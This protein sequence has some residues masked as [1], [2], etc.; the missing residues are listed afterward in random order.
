MNSVEYQPAAPLP[1]GLTADAMCVDYG[2]AAD[3]A[4]ACRREAAL[5]DYSF[6]L[7]LRVEGARA[8]EAI[9]DLCGRDFSSLATGEIRYAL[10]ADAQ[11]WLVS[12]LTVWRTAAETFEIMSG[13]AADVPDIAAALAPYGVETFDVSDQTAVF[14]IQG[15]RTDAVLGS[16]ADVAVERIPFFGFRDTH[17]FGAVCRI[18]R[19]GFT[20]LDG[21]EILCAV[22]DA[23]R[24]W[25]L[26]AVRARPAGFAAADELRLDAGLALFSKEFEPP[27]SAAD[28]GLR[29]IRPN[30]TG[31]SERAPA[32][33]SRVCF[34][35]QAGVENAGKAAATVALE[36]MPGA[37][38]PP[39]PGALAVTSLARRPASRTV[40]GMGYVARA[41]RG[42]AVAAPSG[43]LAD[44]RITRKFSDQ[45]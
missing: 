23:P 31:I 41:H 29:R 9:S 44:I 45:L 14:A 26:L 30:G 34:T 38:F 10:H 7:R 5:F 20:G 2:A 6:L 24:L 18:G 25:R 32:R 43:A 40:I 4:E 21:V 28:V 22:E 35:A 42:D 36:W 27:V 19:L 33:V 1:R 8:V 15:P 3:E 11:G 16:I 12:D 13:R 39:P 17:L 37:T